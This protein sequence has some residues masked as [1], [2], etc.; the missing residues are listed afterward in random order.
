MKKNAKLCKQFVFL[1][2]TGVLVFLGYWM[3][4][5]GD[6]PNSP[7]F[8]RVSHIGSVSLGTT[9]PIPADATLVG[10]DIVPSKGKQVDDDIN[11]I[12]M[13]R[14][15]VSKLKELYRKELSKSLPDVEVNWVVDKPDQLFFVVFR[16][17]GGKSKRERFLCSLGVFSGLS[18]VEGEVLGLSIEEYRQRT[19]LIL[20]VKRPE[21]V[22]GL[23]YLPVRFRP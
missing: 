7:E 16:K 20:S 4:L 23:I 22:G 13:T 6:T 9:I 5:R 14:V 19:F 17:N 3:Y 12:I 1:I 21:E 8:Q 2:L 18:R 15:S 11:Y 10:L